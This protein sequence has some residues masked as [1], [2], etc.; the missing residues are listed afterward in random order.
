MATQTPVTD[1][2]FPKDSRKTYA[3]VELVHGESKGDR[4]YRAKKARVQRER[5][6]GAPAVA[7]VGTHALVALWHLAKSAEKMRRV[8]AFAD[9][10]AAIGDDL[11]KKIKAVAVFT[12][13]TCDATQ[14]R[15]TLEGVRTRTLWG[16]LADDFVRGGRIA[17]FNP[18]VSGD[19]FAVDEM[20]ES[21]LFPSGS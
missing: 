6:S 12:N 4:A 8:S 5:Q 11:P 13:Q 7:H 20:A 15:K 16:E 17:P 9:V 3:L 21:C 18:F 19:S 2:I 1:E 10:R 14:G